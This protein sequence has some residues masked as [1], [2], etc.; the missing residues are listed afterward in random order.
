MIAM[1]TTAVARSMAWPTERRTC[2]AKTYVRIATGRVV[3]G[4]WLPETMYLEAVTNLRC[5]LGDVKCQQ[6]PEKQLRRTLLLRRPPLLRVRLL[7]SQ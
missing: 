5:C 3:E 4:N 6:F 2:S 1:N 7:R